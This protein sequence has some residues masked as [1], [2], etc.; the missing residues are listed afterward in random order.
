LLEQYEKIQG[1]RVAEIV[2]YAKTRRCRHGH[3]SAYLGGRTITQC[4]SCDNCLGLPPQPQAGNLPEEWQQWQSILH[5][6]AVASW[7]WDTLINVLRGCPEAPE[8]AHHRPGFGTLSSCSAVA[9]NSMLERLFKAR[10]LRR[11]R[12]HNSVLIKLTSFARQVLDDA[13]ALR[14]LAATSDA[15][16][17]AQRKTIWQQK[18]A[19]YPV[20]GVPSVAD[21]DPLFQRL[22]IWRLN[23][24]REAGVSAFVIAHNSL[25]RAIAA[26]R[27]HTEQEL[28]AIKGMGPRKVEKYGAELLALVREETGH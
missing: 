9:I 20:V 28:L 12:L 19:L 7:D 21:D 26:L 15:Q 1:Q 2:A 8:S 24:A 14:A 5:C 3:I 10:L 22:R 13:I 25:L 23:K 17:T 6:A 18:K 4:Q 11:R 16:M 27:P